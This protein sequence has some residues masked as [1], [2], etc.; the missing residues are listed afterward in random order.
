MMCMVI[1]AGLIVTRMCI[2]G[3]GCKAIVLFR[4]KINCSTV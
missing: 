2:V 3:F 4:P 1:Y